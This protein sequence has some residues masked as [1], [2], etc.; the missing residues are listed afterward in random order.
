MHVNPFR[1]F[2]LQGSN[3][4]TTG[5]DGL[6][7]DIF[8]GIVTERTELGS[9]TFNFGS[10]STPY[11]S[12]RVKILDDYITEVNGVGG[13]AIYRWDLEGEQAVPEPATLVLLGT[14][15]AGAAAR[16]LRKSSK[17]A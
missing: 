7:G 16:R 1:N 9:Q 5:F 2:I 10:N 11:S 6:W 14:G 12:Y 17:N 4:T 3:N 15:L 13:F 8:S